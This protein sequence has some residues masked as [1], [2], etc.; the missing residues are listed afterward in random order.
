MRINV[1]E[2]LAALAIVVFAGAMAYIGSSYPR[3]TLGAMGAG[4]FPMMI[5]L[6]TAAI[7]LVVLASVAFSAAPAPTIL[8]RPA[9][10]ALASMLAWA[11]L[12]ERFGLVPASVALILLASVAQPPFR[13]WSAII[14]AVLASAAAVA[15]FVYGFDLP[16]RPLKW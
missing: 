7:G 12:V 14:T 5:S 1:G 4:Y 9:L 3:G 6:A 13:M 16:L 8:W 10:L 2:S 15:I 11:V